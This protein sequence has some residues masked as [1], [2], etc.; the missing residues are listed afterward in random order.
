M[1]PENRPNITCLILFIF[2]FSSIILPYK[3]INLLPNEITPQQKTDANVTQENGLTKISIKVKEGEIKIDLPDDMM[4]GDTISG[5]VTAVP[6]GKDESEKKKNTEKLNNNSVE[7]EKQ[8]SPVAN[9]VMTFNL[10]AN[11][12]NNSFTLNIL[13]SKGKKVDNLNIPVNLNTIETSGEYQIP[14]LGQTGRPVN[15]QGNFDGDLS[16]TTCEIGD[17][18][19]QPI[20]E[21]P[22][23]T[24]FQSPADIVGMTSIKLKEGNTEVVQDFRNLGVSLSASKLDLLKGE[25]TDL[26]I[27]VSGLQDINDEI[28]LNLNCTGSAN[29]SGGNVQNLQLSPDDVQAD[30]SVTQ[31]RT[32]TGFQTGNFNIVANVIVNAK[33]NN[34][35]NEVV[36]VEKDPVNIGNENNKVWWLKV[37]IADGKIIDIY[38]KQDF[39][40]NLKFCDWI[41]IK[42]SKPDDT[43]DIFVTNYNKVDDP[44]K[45]CTLTDQTVHVEGDPIKMPNGS[46]QIR[47]KTLDG[48]DIYIYVQSPNKPDLKFC[49]W[50]KLHNCKKLTS[51]TFA[52]DGYDVTEDPNKKPP[53]GVVK[54]TPTPTP[55][56]TPIPTPPR[57]AVVK[58]C[59]NGTIRNKKVV[60]ETF[61]ILEADS[62]ISLSISL[63][64][65]NRVF[66][67]D[68]MAAWLQGIATIG[69]EL[70]EHLPEDAVV[71]NGVAGAVL[72]YVELGGDIIGAIAKSNAKNINVFEVKA[73]FSGE[74][75]KVTAVCTTYEICVNNAWIPKTEYSETKE[76]TF[77]S[78]SITVN[79]NHNAW[80]KI[81]KKSRGFIF[82]PDRAEKYFMTEFLGELKKNEEKYKGFKENCK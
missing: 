5:T 77:Y 73:T 54:P 33:P 60:T 71:G 65:G 23:K 66:A 20:A 41:E 11:L 22:R 51:N 39:K 47:V 42:E 25:T 6:N 14:N 26:Q 69:G 48:K 74:I 38:I 80:D 36:H 34:L 46:W 53:A 9:K 82:D 12:N 56:P 72:R 44:T 4:A 68:G 7:I 59:V 8:K 52:V 18:T 45:P 62:K 2:C 61:E 30:G 35:T 17:K 28:P 67:A 43:G 40:P 76:K 50:I 31:Q 21:S 16:N 3:R 19:A 37:K 13:D 63:D 55:I 27:K 57:V 24:V 29:M 79:T 78:K 58:P 1:L 49:N 81:T 10:P 75:T 32:L 15:I 64:K 70:S